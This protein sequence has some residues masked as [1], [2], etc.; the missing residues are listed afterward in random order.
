METGQALRIVLA[1]LWT[2]IYQR[3]IM[4][5]TSLCATPTGGAGIGSEEWLGSEL[6]L[7]ET[8]TYLITSRLYTLHPTLYQLRLHNGF[9]CY[10]HY[11]ITIRLVCDN[12][13]IHFPCLSHWYRFCNFV[14]TG[15]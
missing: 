5:W 10:L 12:Y 11:V 7:I 13:V 9:V 15:V 3:D 2:T 8:T 14:V 4:Y 1:P 6:V